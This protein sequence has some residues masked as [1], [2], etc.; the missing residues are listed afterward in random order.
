M[1]C[2]VVVL[3]C[4]SLAACPS[5][6]YQFHDSA[7][8]PAPATETSSETLSPGT[9]DTAAWPPPPTPTEGAVE[10]CFD[11]VVSGAETDVDCGGPACPPCGPGQKC[12]GPWDCLDDL[13]I[14]NLC[15]LPPQCRVAEDCPPAPCRESL[16]D[17]EQCVYLDLDGIKCDDGD[18]CTDSDTCIAGQC[19]GSPREC[20]GFDGPCQQGFC[21]PNS[22]NC[23]IEF[24]NDGEPCEDGL[25]CTSG[26]FCAQ[27]Q[28]VGKPG[29]V[30]LTDFNDPGGWVFDPPWMIGP[31]IASACAANGFE[32]PPEDH[33]PDGENTL[34][35][36]EIGGCLP[37]E[38][39][40]D[41]ACL[42]SPPIDALQLPAPVVL[43]Y[44]SQLSAA[45][46][47]LRKP[48]SARVEVWS[49]KA[50][51]SVFESKNEPFDEPEWTPHLIDITPFLNSA[52]MVR[53]CHHHPEPG[54]PPVAG[55]SVDDVYIGP[56]ECQPP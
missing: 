46:L 14:D 49:G 4:L 19:L 51:N 11:G 22:G 1:H 43:L 8:P 33:S 28:C 53:F 56:P 47:P 10:L 12:A 6:I 5:V 29:P 52:L 41:G 15:G 54:L 42:T 27:G 45:P 25:T 50:W 44:W 16:C 23:A 55:W 31:A 18:L 35:G 17:D 21:N 30:W 2:V 24:M 40:P 36:A 34:A 13:C 48:S 39:L 26:D 3:A 32:D 37:S 20:G 7:S 38:P 9:E